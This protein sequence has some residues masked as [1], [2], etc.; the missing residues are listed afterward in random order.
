M[1]DKLE[2]WQNKLENWQNNLEKQQK[3]VE[4]RT[5]C[6]KYYKLFNTCLNWLSI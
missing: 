3:M 5:F 1:V 6:K 2:K 4:I